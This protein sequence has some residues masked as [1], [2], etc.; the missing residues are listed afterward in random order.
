MCIISREVK[1]TDKLVRFVLSPDLTV[2]PDVKCDLP[3][4]GV[5]ISAD[6][7]AVETA[8]NKKAFGRGFKAAAHADSGLPDLV[9]TLLARQALSLFSLA[10]KAGLIRTGFT[11]VLKLIEDKRAATVVHARDGAEDGVRKIKGKVIAAYGADASVDTIQSFT[12]EELSLALGRSNVIHAA[13][14]D[15][16]LTK[17]FVLRAKKYE[18]YWHGEPLSQAVQ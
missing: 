12:S 8:V 3:G 16:G 15:A 2:V 6:K 5:W 11:K 9:G 14:T 17:E 1:P 4:R 7:Y 10:Q 13:M 18:S